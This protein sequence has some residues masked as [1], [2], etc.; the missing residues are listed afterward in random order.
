M[1]TEE[2]K[3]DTKTEIVDGPT[4]E[5][6]DPP[7]MYESSD[8]VEVPG[9]DEFGN[10]IETT[11][12]KL[13]MGL[14]FEINEIT[15]IDTQNQRYGIKGFI[16]RIWKATKQD[17]E[18][19]KTNSNEYSPQIK[20][21]FRFLNSVEV[22]DIDNGRIR[23]KHNKY[24]VQYITFNIQFTE[25]FEIENFPFDVQDL[26]VVLEEKYDARFLSH[27]PPPE[28]V[29]TSYIRFDKTWFS[30]TDW[31]VHNVDMCVAQN[32]YT[33]H[34][35]G[36]SQEMVIFRIQVKRKW[37]GVIYR[38]ILWLLFLGLYMNII[39]YILF[40]LCISAY[41]KYV[42]IERYYVMVNVWYFCG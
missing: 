33:S 9:F 27:V 3:D 26:T 36:Q 1:A 5:S 19:Y 20:P 13:K 15:F 30:T 23:V 39:C 12:K 16:V 7:A 29:Y 24:N 32:P 6:L 37:K 14:R 38:L 41:T 21:K 8:C 42:N 25:E 4:E 18:N 34:Y 28:D 11:Y 2:S 17:L 40:H 22:T 10:Q 31:S 35:K